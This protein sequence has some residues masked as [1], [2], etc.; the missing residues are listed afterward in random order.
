MSGRYREE[1]VK[2]GQRKG[3]RKDQG[4]EPN[5]LPSVW[6]YESNARRFIRVVRTVGEIISL[7][8]Y[9]SRIHIYI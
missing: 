6:D 8:I 4:V 7:L 5:M 9:N 3:E 1:F 2:G